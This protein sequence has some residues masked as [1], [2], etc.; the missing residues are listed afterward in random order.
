M[1][2]NSFSVGSITATVTADVSQFKKNI[3]GIQED[4]RVFG[5]KITSVASSVQKFALIVGAAGIAAAGLFT[6]QSIDAAA[7]AQKE[8]AKFNTIIQNSK[9]PTEQLKNAILDA[10][11]AAVKLGIDDEEAAVSIA[12]FYQRTG[13][14][15]EAIRL[16]NVAMDLAKD[17]NMTLTEAQKMVGMVLS[18]NGKALKQYGIDLKDSATPMEALI[19]LQGKV[20][21]SAQRVSETYAGQIEV[22]NQTFGNFKETIGA[23]FLPSLTDVT[24]SL[25]EIVVNLTQ[26]ELKTGT[27]KGILEAFALTLTTVTNFIKEHGT[28]IMIVAGILTTFFL[29]A[30]VAVGIEMVVNTTTALINSTLAIIQFGLEGWKAI[31]M[32]M[33]K[34]VQLTLATAAFI[35]HTTVTIAQT[36]A[37]GALTVATWLLNAALAVLTSPIFLVVAAIVALI[38]IGYLLIKN[39][40]SVKAFGQKMIDDLVAKFNSFV[41]ALRNIGGQILDALT[42]PF[43]DAWNRI[44][45]TMNKI[46]DALDFTKRHSPSVLDIVKSGVGKV[47]SALG[48]LQFNTALSPTMVAQTVSNGGQSMSVASINIDLN[49]AIIGSQADATSIGELIG[50]GIIKKLQ[51]S[52][53][54]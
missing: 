1:A 17:K 43:N 30:L 48:D 19:E 23:I 28:Q 25:S 13:D 16:N 49:G 51:Y 4:T 40:D 8:M 11:S 15:T 26:W 2:N 50:D 53:R 6:K 32:L 37:S 54:I 3:Q 42:A 29:P 12:R 41:G 46:K 35:L 5:D 21:G 24:K 33:V 18:G 14:L 34:I 20:A 45:D 47:N 9:N 44:K 36:V 22:F 10:A 39:W 38:A 7:E 27:I 52:V 31:A